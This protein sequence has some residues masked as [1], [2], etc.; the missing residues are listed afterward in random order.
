[1]S[2]LQ[3]AERLAQEVV[4]LRAEVKG[5]ER[6]RDLLL[7]YCYDYGNANGRC[8]HGYPQHRGL[9]CGL[10]GHD[11]SDGSPCPR[12][13]CIRHALGGYKPSSGA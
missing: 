12:E 3:E 13:A 9:I 10:C 11:D 4:R 6:E 1:M 5:L 8:A 7:H 2:A